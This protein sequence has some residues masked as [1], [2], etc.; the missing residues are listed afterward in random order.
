MKERPILM[1]APMIKT[2]LAGNKTQTRRIAKLQP[3][4]EN[5]YWHLS[6]KNGIT[7]VYGSQGACLKALVDNWCPYGVSGDRLWVKETFGLWRKTSVYCD[8]FEVGKEALRGLTIAQ[9][10]TEYGHSELNIAYRADANDEGPWYPS[11]FMPRWASRLT[12]EITE[13]RVQRLQEIS[14]EDAIAEGITSHNVLLW[15]IDAANKEKVEPLYW[16]ETPKQSSDEDY[17]RKCADKKLVEIIAER[18]GNGT[19]CFVDGGWSGHEADGP[20]F[21]EMC[22]VALEVSYTDYAVEQELEHFETY[23]AGPIG[24]YEVNRLAGSISGEEDEKR[25]VR[26]GYRWLWESI[27][28]VGSW[29]D[30]PWVW[31]VNFRRIDGKS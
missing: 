21:C 8:E 4:E 5:G 29:K 9:H 26:V 28:G 31:C 3:W 13:V 19:D 7:G 1:S 10:E 6:H 18:G 14:E 12:L 27:N 17:C 2:L 30:N 16:I 22:G 23:N 15:S 11:I 20:R 25:F 24:A